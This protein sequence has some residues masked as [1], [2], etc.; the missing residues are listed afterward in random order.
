MAHGG[1]QGA[2]FSRTSAA[3]RR[4][5]IYKTVTSAVGF[6]APP[7]TRKGGTQDTQQEEEFIDITTGGMVRHTEAAEDLGGAA[8]DG[9]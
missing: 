8:Q 1:K 6:S 9:A 7:V 3:G 5:G 4:W 2:A